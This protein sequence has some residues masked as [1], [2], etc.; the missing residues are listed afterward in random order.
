MLS[1]EEI[2]AYI[3]FIAD[4]LEAL[5]VDD[6]NVT[7]CFE[8]DKRFQ[9]LRNQY[10]EC[11]DSLLHYVKRLSALRN[12]FQA[13]LAQRVPLVVDRFHEVGRQIQQAECEKAFWRGVLIHQAAECSRKILAGEIATVRIQSK[14]SRMI[15]AAGTEERNRL[16]RL[17]R[18]SGLWDKV[19]HL[20]RAKLER[21]LDHDKFSKTQAEVIEG[22]CPVT[23][24]H[25]VSVRTSGRSTSLAR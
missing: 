20:S 15:P 7:S 18:E 21:A 19:S 16:D 10:Q 2:E 25:Q 1:G 6:R 5:A 11:P 8:I 4:A 13:L 9:D 24:T 12:R 23:L 17:I 3:R 22:L 14:R